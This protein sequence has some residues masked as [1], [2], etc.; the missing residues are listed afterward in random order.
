M[1]KSNK[2]NKQKIK[3]SW[4]INIRLYKDKNDKSKIN[5]MRLRKETKLYSNFNWTIACK[6][7]QES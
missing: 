1:H 6:L 7:D 5:K 3:L 2:I 4:K